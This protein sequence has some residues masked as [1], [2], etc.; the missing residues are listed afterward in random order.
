CTLSPYT[1]LFRSH[2]P[3]REGDLVRVEPLPDGFDPAMAVRHH[4]VLA[5][6]RGRPHDPRDVR[7]HEGVG[8]QRDA[9]DRQVLSHRTAQTLPGAACRA[10]PCRWPARPTGR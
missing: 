10:G 4:D 1:T 9:I 3:Q 2:P 7:E 6:A 8:R 5:T